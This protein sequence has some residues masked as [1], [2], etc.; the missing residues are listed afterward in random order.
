[1]DLRRTKWG[2]FLTRSLLITESKHHSDL[3]G[4][5]PT[6]MF[7]MAVTEGRGNLWGGKAWKG[8]VKVGQGQKALRYSHNP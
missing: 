3:K 6:S 2:T 8:K 4:E 1:M 7:A 5:T